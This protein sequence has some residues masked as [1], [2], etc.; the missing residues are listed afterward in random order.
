MDLK[1]LYSFLKKEQK[2]TKNDAKTLVED[3]LFQLQ[4]EKL[5]LSSKELEVFSKALKLL[6][7]NSRPIS[8][9]TTLLL[10]LVQ[11]KIT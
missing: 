10:T 8:I 3:V 1:S 4:K 6:E 2:I 11:R 9:I 7:L 5:P